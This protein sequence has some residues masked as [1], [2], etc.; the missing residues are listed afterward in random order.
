MLLFCEDD[1]NVGRVTSIIHDY[2]DFSEERIA[3][4]VIVD[5][6]PEP[7]VIDGNYAILCVNLDSKEVYYKY[8][9]E[10]VVTEPVTNQELIDALGIALLE[11]AENKLRISTL[12][13]TQGE[14]LMEIAMLKLNGGMPNVV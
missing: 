8:V 1:N 6:L 4:G 2:S 3:E 14:L 12:E 5:S 9:D 10:E 11:N 13:S 7:E